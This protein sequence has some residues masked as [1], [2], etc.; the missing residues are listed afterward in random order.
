[1]NLSRL[2]ADRIRT[3]SPDRVATPCFLFFSDVLRL[4]LGEISRVVPPHRIYFSVKANPQD[5]VLRELAARGFAADISSEW[6]LNIA[7]AAGFSPRR[8]SCVG[9]WKPPEF[10]SKLVEIRV[11]QISFETKQEAQWLF[12]HAPQEIKLFARL[13]LSVEHLTV[14]ENMMEEQSPFGLTIEELRELTSFDSFRLDGIHVYTGSDFQEIGDALVSLKKL[15]S[16][17]NLPRVHRLQFGPGLGVSYNLL[18]PDPDFAQLIER[19]DELSAD[20]DVVFEIGRYIV[21]HSTVFLTRVCAVKN[22]GPATV[23]VLDGGMTSFARTIITDARHPTILLGKPVTDEPTR[24]FVL[25]GPTCT[26]LDRIRAHCY[27]DAVR[28]GDVVC[29]LCAGAYGVN[30]NFDGFL[31]HER[32]PFRIADPTQ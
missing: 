16:I 26:P 17:S 31:G 6:E 9:P 11:G 1:M 7:L 5:A 15:A 29:V 3:F 14:S 20:W 25:C 30:L 21:A 13:L 12:S 4:R 2:I 24:R 19:V 10:L 18:R 22:R 23:L 8:I 27:F 32:A 28:E